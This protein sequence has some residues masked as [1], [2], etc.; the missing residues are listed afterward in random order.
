M[1]AVPGEVHALLG[2]NGS[3]KSTLMRIL[4]GEL[5]PDA[6][7]VSLGGRSYAPHTP[8]EALQA[9]VALV[10]QEL[11]L[12]ADLTVAE[13]IWL[14]DEP[15]SGARLDRRR[16]REG[17]RAALAPLGE[18]DLDPDTP[19]RQLAP[20]R[21]QLVEV[22]R[23]LR[24]NARVI[25]FDEP[26]SSL[27]AIEV[28]RLF[29]VIDRLR[30][31][32]RTVI[33]ITHFLDEVGRLADRVTVLRDGE[34][35]AEFAGRGQDA[36]VLASAMAGRPVSEVYVRTTRMPGEVA[37][38]LDQVVGARRPKSVSLEV[39]YGEVVGLAGLDGAGRTETLRLLFGLDALRGGE[40]AVRG[41]VGARAP[42]FRWR[43]AVGLVSEDRKGEGL[44]LTMSLAENVALPSLHHGER[45][46]RGWNR[47]GNA[48]MARL[49]IR[50]A[51]PGQAVG[52]LSG[53]NQ[54]KVA[55]ARLMDPAC[56]VWLLDEPTRGIDVNSKAEIYRLIDAAAQDGAAVVVAG[57][58]LPELLGICDRIAVLRRGT[59]VAMLDARTATETEILRWSASS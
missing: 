27:G 47:R 59:T 49:S 9:G 2:E 38:R 29:A 25:L 23:A 19:I 44:A 20:A 37:L 8:R 16:M 36:D 22:A 17:A 54:Q 28:E 18:A 12:C 24:A 21:C 7:T 58:Y 40:I 43:Q 45:G 55:L 1:T 42:R 26:T 13:N 30:A 14:G 33:Y 57:S 48:A 32:G 5:R 56:R 39:H 10:H 53:G 46:P 6:G 15:R 3:G 52:A 34:S 31:D 11:A 51:G 41:E 50:A 4:H 35:V